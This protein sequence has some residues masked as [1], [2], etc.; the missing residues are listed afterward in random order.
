MLCLFS[1]GCSALGQ[2]SVGIKRTRSSC[3]YPSAELQQQPLV[4]YQ[5]CG[6]TLVLMALVLEVSPG[7]DAEAPALLSPCWSCHPVPLRATSFAEKFVIS[8]E[9]V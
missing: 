1:V 5:V 7:G 3:S 2:L 4:A 8:P 6:V 9:Q